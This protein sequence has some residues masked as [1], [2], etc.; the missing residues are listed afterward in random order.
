MSSDKL[1]YVAELESNLNALGIE[2]KENNK[3]YEWVKDNYTLKISDV[4]NHV[5]IYRNE[6]LQDKLSKEAL[7]IAL[8]IIEQR[9]EEAMFKAFLDKIKYDSTK[10]DKFEELSR[11]ISHDLYEPMYSVVLKH[12]IWT[13]K[14]RLFRLPE[15]CPIF[16]NFYGDAGCGKSEFV[17]S[18]FSIMP[19]TLKSEASQ[20]NELFNDERQTFRF[21]E[22]FVIVMDE[23]TGLDKSDINKL[24]NQIDRT[25][26]VY[27]QLG[28]NQ[29]NEGRNNAQLIGTSNTRLSNIIIADSDI[30]KWCEID[31]YA[32]PDN[33]VPTKMVT[34]L[35]KYDWLSLWQSVDENGPSP[36]HD[37]NVYK[38]FKDWTSEK[39]KHESNTTEFIDYCMA[40]YFTVIKTKMEIMNE[41][42]NYEDKYTMSW[43][44]IKEQ[45]IK[46]G[47]T[48]FRNKLIRGV[49][50]PKKE[51][52]FLDFDYENIDNK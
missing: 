12:M 20:A 17:K 34:P 24:K 43:P 36:F 37:S 41:Y 27:R 16:I 19:P 38:E 39:S 2:Y 18:M 42:E 35:Q 11:F 23:L 52:E 31:F 32:Y 40:T 45:L 46:R 9:H 10:P 6:H 25:I 3:I 49:T 50:F 5:F 48:P 14:R 51:E 22:S 30:R 13:I 47:C 26:V 44:K 21:V 28:F 15:Y 4:Y 1:N 7:Q 29:T 8:Q 33:E